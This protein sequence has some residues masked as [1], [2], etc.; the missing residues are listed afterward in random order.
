[1]SY[2]K[3]YIATVCKPVHDIV[4]YPTFICSFESGEYEKEAKKL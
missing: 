4:N 3:N 1:M 2:S